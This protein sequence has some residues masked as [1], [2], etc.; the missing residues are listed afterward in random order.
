MLH[1]K[2]LDKMWFARLGGPLVTNAQNSVRQQWKHTYFLAIFHIYSDLWFKKP[3]KV[4]YTTLCVNLKVNAKD[5]VISLPSDDRCLMV[6][7]QSCFRASCVALS[8]KT[9]LSILH[10]VPGRTERMFRSERGLAVTLT[11]YTLMPPSCN[12]T[13][14]IKATGLQFTKPCCFALC[15]VLLLPLKSLHR[16]Q[17][18]FNGNL[19][20]ICHVWLFQLFLFSQNIFSI[21]LLLISY[22][23]TCFLSIGADLVFFVWHVLSCL[24]LVVKRKWEVSAPHKPKLSLISDSPSTLA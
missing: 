1:K 9:Y 8:G 3:L 14:S 24:V 19:T 2:M 5:A 20:L 15:T 4:P 7:T 22:Q 13:L 21:L 18:H 6:T 11:N 12:H 16:C 10:Y 23:K 17:V